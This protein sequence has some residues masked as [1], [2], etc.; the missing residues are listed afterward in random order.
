MNAVN[1]WGKPSPH[2][3]KDPDVLKLVEIVNAMKISGTGA[4]D[5]NQVVEAVQLVS[6]LSSDALRHWMNIEEEEDVHEAIIGDLREEIQKLFWPWNVLMVKKMM[7][8]LLNC[9][10]LK[11]KYHPSVSIALILKH[12]RTLHTLLANWLFI[13]IWWRPERDL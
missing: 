10:C 6:Q 2:T 7:K 12:L 5:D 8:R 4:G 9:R 1:N 3:N 11:C 13:S